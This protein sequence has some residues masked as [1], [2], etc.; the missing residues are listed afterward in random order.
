[1]KVGVASHSLNTYYAI[2][3]PLTPTA[4]QAPLVNSNVAASPASVKVSVEPL[5]KFVGVRMLEPPSVTCTKNFNCPSVP[6]ASVNASEA[7]VDVISVIEDTTS[8]APAPDN[9]CVNE[10]K[11]VAPISTVS[12][13]AST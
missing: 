1:M 9:A 3:A 13:A 4:Y 11:G 6:S 12:L 5:P 2:V 8:T 10:N 7:P